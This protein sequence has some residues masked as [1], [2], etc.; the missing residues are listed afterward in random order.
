FGPHADEDLVECVAAD[1]AAAPPEIALD[2]LGRAVTNERAALAALREAGVPLVAINPGH[3]PT[4][5]AS[6]ARHG[7]SLVLEDPSGFN[8]VLEDVVDRFLASGGRRPV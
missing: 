8:R 6:L 7:V 5:T 3:R 2:A 4:H 1:M